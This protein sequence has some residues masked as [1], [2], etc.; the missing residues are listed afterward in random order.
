MPKQKE[1]TQKCIYV[2][3]HTYIYIYCCTLFSVGG[4]PQTNR[5]PSLTFVKMYL[6]G[7]LLNTIDTQRTRN[8]EVAVSWL[9]RAPTQ[10]WGPPRRRSLQS[11]S[12]VLTS[13]GP[14]R[15]LKRVTLINRV[16]HSG[17]ASKTLGLQQARAAFLRQGF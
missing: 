10:C 3:T 16:R 2:Y 1:R 12:L 4:C 14:R 17:S 8:I 11:G 5:V 7:L 6:V 9:L 15:A 13:L